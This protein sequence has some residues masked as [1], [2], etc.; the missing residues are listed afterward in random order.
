MAAQFGL[1]AAQEA[2]YNRV[3]F[4]G[5]EPGH[6][7]AAFV[8]RGRK[9]G[10]DATIRGTG[11]GPGTWTF[12]LP[13]AADDPSNG[14]SGG[15]DDRISGASYIAMPKTVPFDDATFAWL[16][17]EGMVGL[18]WPK[19]NW[20]TADVGSSA[21]SRL[22]EAAAAL[23]H[24]GS[25]LE[26]ESKKGRKRKKRNVNSHIRSAERGAVFCRGPT[27]WAWVDFIKVNGTEFVAEE[28]GWGKG[29]V[30]GIYTSG[31]GRVLNFTE[32]AG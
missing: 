1:P 19:G 5:L 4:T 25:S 2:E 3:T 31:D 6:V 12:D 15:D 17:A 27:R 16:S 30:K 11:W 9:V 26:I 13:P 23:L 29:K 24:E 18:V 14:L 21:R 22:L 32:G 28:G 8:P 20:F 7:T 10:C